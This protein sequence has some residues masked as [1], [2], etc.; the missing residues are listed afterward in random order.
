[1]WSTLESAGRGAA[2]VAGLLGIMTIGAV[3]VWLLVTLLAL[4]AL[5]AESDAME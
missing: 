1:M 3:A 2:Q 4:H 5:R